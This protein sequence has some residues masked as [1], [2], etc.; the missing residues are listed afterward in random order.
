MIKVNDKV[1]VTNEGA[2]CDRH[3]RAAKLLGATRFYS[4]GMASNG[5]EGFVKNVMQK[6]NFP[7]SVLCL[8]ERNDGQQFVIG[9]EGLEVIAKNKPTHKTASNYLRECATVQAERGKQYDSSGSGERSFAAAAAAFNAIT[10]RDL[11]GS[12]IC[13]LLQILKDVRQYSDP[14]RLHEDSLLDKVSYAS[15]HAEEINREFLK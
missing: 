2:T 3:E 11:K 8:F 4:R 5:D 15:L 14:S 9:M 13:L 1:K 10:G 12:D 6:P 7:S